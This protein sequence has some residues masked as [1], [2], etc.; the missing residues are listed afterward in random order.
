[1]PIRGELSLRGELLL[2]ELRQEAELEQISLRLGT[3]DDVPKPP[4]LGPMHSPQSR[5]ASGAII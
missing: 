5:R 3:D 1:M 4:E 2:R